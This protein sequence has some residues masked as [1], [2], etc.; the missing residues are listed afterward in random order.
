MSPTSYRAAPPR[1]DS[2]S[3]PDAGESVNNSTTLSPRRAR[4]V[5]VPRVGPLAAGG[6]ILR[7]HRGDLVRG[8]AVL[9]QLRLQGVDA[10]G[11]ARENRALH[12]AVGR[13]ERLE[14]VL[15][16]HVLGNLET[17]HRLDLPLGRAVPERVRAPDDV[18][19]TE[20][21]DQGADEGSGEARVGDGGRRE[22]G[23][24]L[25]VDVLHAE[26]A[27][28]LGQIARPLDLPGLL[29]LG[30]RRVGRFQEVA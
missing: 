19:G 5:P 25:P 21:F 18:V 24:D 8:D 27:G 7:L 23:A 29:E 3:V 17:A 9:R 20:A 14:A 4:Y 22:R 28:N 15:L 16:L 13:A 26:L 11:V 2:R 6:Q 1:D 10:R 12:W 30:Q